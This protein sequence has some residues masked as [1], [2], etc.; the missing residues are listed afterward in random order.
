MKNVYESAFYEINTA[1]GMIR[2][3]GNEL[4]KQDGLSDELF[5]D[6]KQTLA[7]LQDASQF[8]QNEILNEIMDTQDTLHSSQQIKRE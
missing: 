4:A 2:R 1:I 8:Y 3:L 5:A 6:T 7:K